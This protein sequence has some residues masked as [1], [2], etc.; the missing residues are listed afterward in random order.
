MKYEYTL[1]PL[2]IR[3]KQLKT[4]MVHS[5]CYN[6]FGDTPEH[7]RKATNFYCGIADAGAATVTLSIGTFPDCDGQRSVMSN[8]EMDDPAVAARFTQM[9]AEIHKHGSLCSASL[10]NVEPQQFSICELP[11]D[12]WDAI[13][14]T[15]DYNPNFINKPT[16]SEAR[17]EGMIQDYVK[18]CTALKEMGFD[19]V[20][21]YMCY[22]ASILATALSPVLN[23]RTD[24]YGGTTMEERARLPLEV[25]RRVRQAVGEDFIIECQISGEE[26]APGYTVEDWLNFCALCDDYVD[27]WQIRGWEGSCVHV[28]G[29][30]S[31]KEAPFALRYA[32]AFCKRG[33]KAKAA[34]VGG[35]GDPDMM[36]AFLR[37]GKTDL[38]AMARGF[39]C[40]PHRMEKLRQEQG[41]D[42]APCLRCMKCLHPSCPVNPALSLME[43]PTVYPDLPPEAKKVAVVG[44]GAA[45]MRAAIECARLGHHVTLFEKNSYLGGQML[46]A[47]QQDFKWQFGDFLRWLIRQTEKCGCE[48][49]LNTPADPQ[50]LKREGYDAIIC[51]VGSQPKMPPVPG[52]DAPGVWNIDEVY[53]GSARLGHHV[54]VVGGG[55]SGRETGL[56]LARKGHQVTVLTRSQQ[57]YTDN[58]HCILG[59][60]QAYQNCGNLE[61]VE[62]AETTL[63]EPHRVCCTVKV[64]MPRRAL[65]FNSVSQL[66]RRPRQN[67]APIPGLIYPEFPFT[68]PELPVGGAG[69]N[70]RKTGFPHPKEEVPEIRPEEIV[71]EHRIIDCDSV[72]VSGGRTS[73]HDAAAAFAGAAPR[74]FLVGDAIEPGSLAEVATSA[75]A[76]AREI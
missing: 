11:Q 66:S 3:G 23:K 4:H 40:E 57:G 13:P 7:F 49:R 22:R 62:F 21:F 56:Y 38:I 43:D 63:I 72:V 10:M 2:T 26:E 51:A 6:M 28:T 54:V 35:F 61:M 32:E 5:R 59:V 39:M 30:N 74:V 14:K 64:N 44:G 34:P 73:C 65:T 8:M 58:N 16:I 52:A 20:T 53:N 46:Y 76:A 1:K 50:E 41:D 71:T 25:L 60:V 48:I 19:Q 18:Q 55:D 42:I 27:I 33:L 12:E 75:F 15:G 67:A 17:I 47:E 36:E 70:G 29:F 45:G 31:S 69:K 68:P 24:R 9:I 37:E